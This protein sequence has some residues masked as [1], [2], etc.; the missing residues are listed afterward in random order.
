VSALIGGRFRRTDRKRV[1]IASLPFEPHQVMLTYSSSPPDP[2]PELVLVDGA[3]GGKTRLEFKWN[4]LP[5]LSA[6]DAA[7][8]NAETTRKQGAIDSLTLSRS[9]I[10]SVFY[11]L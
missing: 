1:R 8:R 10:V 5:A 2:T 7:I 6:I 11:S 4:M 9:T 3:R